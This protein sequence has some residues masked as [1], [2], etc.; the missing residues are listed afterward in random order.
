MTLGKQWI[1]NVKRVE[2]KVYE[3]GENRPCYSIGDTKFSLILV[4]VGR[5]SFNNSAITG[6]TVVPKLAGVKCLQ[7]W[8][9]RGKAVWY[10]SYG[11]TCMA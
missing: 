5:V 7:T 2:K 6:S 3:A 4:K 8:F 1:W 9:T 11:V 10:M